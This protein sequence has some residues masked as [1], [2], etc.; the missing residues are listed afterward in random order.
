MLV[1]IA[2]LWYQ[3]C[4]LFEGQVNT[5]P[6][7]S[8]YCSYMMHVYCNFLA[9]SPFVFVPFHYCTTS[10]KYIYYIMD[11]IIF[12]SVRKFNVCVKSE[13][14]P[15]CWLNVWLSLYER[16]LDV[17]QRVDSHAAHTLAGEKSF[18]HVQKCVRRLACEN[19]SGRVER[20]PNPYNVH[21]K[22]EESCA[23]RVGRVTT[24]DKIVP[25]VGHT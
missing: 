25:R 6:R 10:T 9:Y 7:H 8:V 12:A 21:K 15:S 5:Y 14:R 3:I 1:Y 11:V 17:L 13:E 23:D 4:I 18:V 16:I 22:A 19:E 20:S 24:C 2:E